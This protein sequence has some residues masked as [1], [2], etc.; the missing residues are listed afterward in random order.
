[1]DVPL[2]VR[3]QRLSSF[4]EGIS[5][6]NEDE[7]PPPSLMI[8]MKPPQSRETLSAILPNWRHSIANLDR[9][10]IRVCLLALARCRNSKLTCRFTTFTV[11]MAIIV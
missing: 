3:Y 7:I 4:E 11:A 2:K 6:G 5:T 8:E 9:F 10:F 1:M